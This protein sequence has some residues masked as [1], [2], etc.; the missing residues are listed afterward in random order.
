MDDLSGLIEAQIA[1]LRRYARALTRDPT[2]VDDLVQETVARALSKIRLW[3]EYTDM[4]AWLFTILHNQYINQFRRLAREG[5]VVSGGDNEL[6]ET[7]P[8]NQID[9]LELRDLDRALTKLPEEQRSVILLIGLEG[10]PYKKV[11]KITGIPVGTVRS[12]ASRGREELRRLM[13]KSP[14]KRAEAA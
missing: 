8:P 11:A 13:G 10:M 5:K 3:Q 2:A 6:S 12:R 14:D 7:R 4:R 1:P 9:R